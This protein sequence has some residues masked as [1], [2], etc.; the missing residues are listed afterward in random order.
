MDKIEPRRILGDGGLLSER[1]RH[2]STWSGGSLHLLPRY[3]S[4]LYF[5]GLLSMVGEYGA[6]VFMFFG[7]V[8]AKAVLKGTLIYP[9]RVPGPVAYLSLGCFILLDFLHRIVFCFMYTETR[10]PNISWPLLLAV[11]TACSIWSMKYEHSPTS[12]YQ[13]AAAPLALTLFNALRLMVR[14]LLSNQSLGKHFYVRYSPLPHTNVGVLEDAW[15]RLKSAYHLESEAEGDVRDET[16]DGNCIYSSKIKLLPGEGLLTTAAQS[17]EHVRFPLFVHCDCC[18]D[19]ATLIRLNRSRDLE[20][21][22]VR[23]RLYEAWRQG[24]NAILQNAKVRLS[25][26]FLMAEGEEDRFAQQCGFNKLC[27]T[28]ENFA[29][30]IHASHVLQ[31]EYS[32]EMRE[33]FSL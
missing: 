11:E 31:T 28:C 20:G 19:D 14:S 2:H 23:S 32:R 25:D 26:G 18:A 15:T 9:D 6:S 29:S 30:G 24:R 5:T 7:C 22:L 16:Q 17:A 27:E 4:V 8:E 10:I 12:G 1:R 3:V 33:G 21:L 13:Y